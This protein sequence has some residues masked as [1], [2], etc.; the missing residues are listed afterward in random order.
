[1][2]AC[3]ALQAADAKYV[4]RKK[5]PGRVLASAHA[6]EREFRV[7][8]ALRNTH[9]PVPAALCLCEDTSVLG[10]PFYVMSHVQV[11]SLEVVRKPHMSRQE[12]CQG[13][14]YCGSQLTTRRCADGQ[15]SRH[16]SKRSR[17]SHVVSRQAICRAASLKIPACQSCSHRSVKLPIMP[18]PPRWQHCT[19]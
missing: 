6:V 4:L 11:G 3:C 2:H 7:L 9:V 13:C 15:Q 17:S 14:D 18:W 16:I 1:M 5:P 8:A 12:A 10:T 19:P